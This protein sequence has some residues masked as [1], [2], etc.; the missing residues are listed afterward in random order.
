M[1]DKHEKPAKPEKPQPVTM[2]TINRVSEFSHDGETYEVDKDG[3]VDIPVNVV[4]IAES[5]GFRIAT[6][7]DLH[8]ASKAKK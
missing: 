3:L 6:E 7:E 5:H 2:K 8:P 4:A 1:S